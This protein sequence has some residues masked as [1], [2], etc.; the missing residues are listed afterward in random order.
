MKFIFVRHGKDDDAYRGGWSNLDL[1]DVGREQ[2]SNLAEYLYR[3]QDVYKIKH[4][5]SSD[6]VRTM[7]TAKYI[8]DKLELPIIEEPQVREMNNGDLAGMANSVAEVKYPSLYFNTLGMNE[9]YPNGESP[10]EFFERIR[11]WFSQLL[12]DY[13]GKSE[14]VL[15]V[16]HSGVINLVYYIVNHMEWSNKTKSFKVSNC[17]IHVLDSD[18]MTF[19]CENKTC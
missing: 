6:L 13:S 17:S 11:E 15:I 2:A 8:S 9:K 10:A 19:E 3:K 12:H 18:T 5:I 1:V 7:T 4:I 14:N 16:T